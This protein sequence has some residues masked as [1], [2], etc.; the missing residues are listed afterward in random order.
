VLNADVLNWNNFLKKWGNLVIIG[1]GNFP[2]NAK[3][4]LKG[5][6]FF[7]DSGYFYYLRN[8]IVFGSILDR[9]MPIAIG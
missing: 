7:V 2:G 4:I 6:L 8:I 9:I 5:Q 1:F 3:I